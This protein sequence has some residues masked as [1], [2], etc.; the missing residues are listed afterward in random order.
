[1]KK[2]FLRILKHSK[3]KLLSLEKR[4]RENLAQQGFSSSLIDPVHF[5]QFHTSRRSRDDIIF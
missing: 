2:A 5:W 3:Y 1:M 4:A